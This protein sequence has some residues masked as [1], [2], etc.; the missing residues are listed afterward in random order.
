MNDIFIVKT[1]KGAFY[2][3]DPSD[4]PRVMQY[5]WCKNN[6]G[7][8][9][10]GT[11]DW[12][13]MHALIMTPPKGAQVDHENRYK[14]DNRRRNLRIVTQGYN[15]HVRQKIEAIDG[16]TPSTKYRGVCAP[17]KYKNYAKPYIAQLK[18]NGKTHN[19]GYFATAQEAAL[20]YNKKATEIY[21]ERAVLNI[22]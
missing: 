13:S 9:T 2:L 4:A 20:A 11:S 1:K 19:L 14:F 15:N 6:G 10:C 18:I 16:W 12:S 3:I 5:T 8:A 17:T 7:Y 22:I 21:G